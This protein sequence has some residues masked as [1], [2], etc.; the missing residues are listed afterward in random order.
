MVV[1]NGVIKSVVAIVFVGVLNDI[2]TLVSKQLSIAL[3]LPSPNVHSFN[4]EGSQDS[5]LFPLPLP[6]IKIHVPLESTSQ[7]Q[8]PV[9][10]DKIIWLREDNDVL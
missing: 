1:Y 6:T 3:L 4:T 7:V 8:D 5:L 10:A 2:H 9:K